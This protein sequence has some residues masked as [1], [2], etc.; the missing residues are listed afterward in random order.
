MSWVEHF[1]ARSV[2]LVPVLTPDH[3]TH[4]RSLMGESTLS[5]VTQVGRSVSRGALLNLIV[6]LSV[7]LEVWRAMRLFEL[8]ISSA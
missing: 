3:T 4:N 8:K 5:D 7:N 1:G 6:A 2:A